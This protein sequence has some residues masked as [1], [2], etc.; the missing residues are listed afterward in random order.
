MFTTAENLIST[1]HPRARGEHTV[2]HSVHRL[3]DGSSPRSRGTFANPQTNFQ[4]RRFIP[5]LAGNIELPPVCAG[6][7]TV[8]PRARGEH[9]PGIRWTLS[10]RGSSPRSRG[11]F[12]KGG[13]FKDR[14][15]FIPALAGNIAI[16]CTLNSLVAV[17]PRARGE[18]ITS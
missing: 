2:K 13:P 5:A 14:F 4:R 10:S 6:L 11:T 15:R 12:Q 17:H 16:S 9:C 3:T 1:V 7:S 8:H 18:H